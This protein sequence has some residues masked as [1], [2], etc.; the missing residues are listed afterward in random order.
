MEQRKSKAARNCEGGPYGI[1][2][3]NGIRP[4]HAQPIKMG[5]PIVLTRTEAQAAII[6]LA[7]CQNDPQAQTLAKRIQSL[8]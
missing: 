3:D 4:V 5:R 7:R 6:A 8:I 1:R 2:L